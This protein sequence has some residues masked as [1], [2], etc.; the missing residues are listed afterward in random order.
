[1]TQILQVFYATYVAFEILGNFLTKRFGPSKTLPLYILTWGI[2][3]TL[4]GIVHNFEGLLATRIFLGVTESGLF[5]SCIYIV[6]MWYPRK[7]QVCFTCLQ[8]LVD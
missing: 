5:P 4:M 8:S 1:M 2:V 6:T 3:L 7:M